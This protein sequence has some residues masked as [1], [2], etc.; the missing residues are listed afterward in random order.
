MRER[1][2]RP[3]E[4]SII[5]V[6]LIKSEISTKEQHKW[7]GWNR[8]KKEVSLFNQPRQPVF[9]HYLKK[10]NI[11]LKLTELILLIL[12]G[13]WILPL[14]SKDLYVFWTEQLLFLMGR[15]VLNH[16]QKPFGIKLINIMFLVFVLLIKW[17][18][19]EPDLR[20]IENRF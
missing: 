5:R 20:I 15:W 8:K 3:K 18:D 11:Y 9:G 19:L 6:R 14:K 12:R 13:M 10:E 17:M 16:N 1:R 7:I 2:P 4:S